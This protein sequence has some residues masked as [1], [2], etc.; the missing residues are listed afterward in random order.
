MTPEIQQA[1]D[2]AV[3]QAIKDHRHDGVL[4]QNIY[5]NQILDPK[6]GQYA[7]KWSYNLAFGE[8]S[9]A[10]PT[11]G[12]TSVGLLTGS[13]TTSGKLA[14]FP[15]RIHAIYVLSLDTTAATITFSNGAGSIGTVAKGTV[16]G[17]MV[18]VTALSATDINGGES[19]TMVSSSAGNAIVITH[20]EFPDN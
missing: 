14:P 9:V 19:I 12:T 17:A 6:F 4:T 3:R 2:A 20:L 7:R 10:R 13:S 16:A 1:I 18:G 8:T 5:L 11:N 15:F